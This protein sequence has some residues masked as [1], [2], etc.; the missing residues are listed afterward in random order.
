MMHVY[1]FSIT[2][3]DWDRFPKELYVK[4]KSECSPS[5]EELL[6]I[7][8]K[9]ETEDLYDSAWKNYCDELR[10]AVKAC[11]TFPVLSK[12][13]VESNYLGIDV[14]RIKLLD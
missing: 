13:G 11:K 6:E 4:S 9:L 14:K 5:R 7:I 12:W 3:N 10:T 1:K 8:D 2:I